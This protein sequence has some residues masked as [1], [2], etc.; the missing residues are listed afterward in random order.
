MNKKL[1]KPRKWAQ[2]VDQSIER[3]FREVQSLKSIKELVPGLL[4]KVN[5]VEGQKVLDEILLSL[6]KESKIF[7]QE[8]E[9]I[10]SF[11]NKMGIQPLA[12]VPLNMPEI[13]SCFSRYLFIKSEDF[14]NPIAVIEESYYNKFIE[15]S[16]NKKGDLDYI[17]LVKKELKLDYSAFISLPNRVKE[18]ISYRKLPKEWD[19]IIKKCSELGIETRVSLFNNSFH[20][21]NFL[22]KKYWDVFSEDSDA[23]LIAEILLKGRQKYKGYDRK[24]WVILDQTPSTDT[25]KLM[26]HANRIPN[27]K[28]IL[29]RYLFSS[30]IPLVNWLYKENFN[31]SNLLGNEEL[32]S[33]KSI[34]Y[35]NKK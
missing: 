7:F 10:M 28:Y 3:Y 25:G 15:S 33:K 11:F 2:D 9:K 5:L 16:L 27:N 21:K 24:A 4:R 14:K 29:A 6:K 18:P 17:A 30:N 35:K 12:F 8:K 26:R 20:F 13:P 31:V 34:F 32:I 22:E 19:N 23:I 1:K